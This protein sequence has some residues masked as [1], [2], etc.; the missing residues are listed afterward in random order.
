[1]ERT[2]SRGRL[3]VGKSDFVI[4]NSRAKIALLEIA[5]ISSAPLSTSTAGR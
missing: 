4:G 3:R 2:G 5:F 1:M